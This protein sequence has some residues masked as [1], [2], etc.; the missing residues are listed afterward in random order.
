[1]LPI[2]SLTSVF[3]GYHLKCCLKMRQKDKLGTWN[4]YNHTTIHMI[5][6]QQG[7]TV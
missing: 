4:E 3:N 1:M 5:Y 7:S 6:K 2:F